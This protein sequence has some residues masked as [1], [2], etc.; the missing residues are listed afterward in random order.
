MEE[1]IKVSPVD[2]NRQIKESVEL[3]KL[4]TE[5][6]ETNQLS[7]NQIVSDKVGIP[8]LTKTGRVDHQQ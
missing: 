2:A 3:S 1:N 4:K 6:V 7:A 5:S 8:S